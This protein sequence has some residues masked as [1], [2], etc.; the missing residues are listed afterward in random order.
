MHILALEPYY[1]G[2]HRAFLDGWITHSRHRWSVL[3]LPPHKWKWR[4]RH[5]A[6]TL[7]EETAALLEDG[8]RFDLLW[9]SDML[10]LAEFLGL[11]PPQLRELPSVLYFHENQLTYP[12][13]HEDQRDLHF[14]FSNFTAA[15]AANA[16]WF[17]SAFH[18]QEF[19]TAT[20]EYLSRM[21]DYA[22]LNALDEVEAKATV[23]HPGIDPFP[24][25]GKRPAGPLHILWAA[26]WE[27][28]KN[29][30]AF[31][32]AV[33]QL[34]ERGVDFCLSVIGQAFREVPDVFESAWARHAKRLKNWGYQQSAEAYRAALSSA[35]VFVSTA[36]HEFFGLSAAEAMSAGCYP[37]L[38][39]RLAYPELLELS[40]RPEMD[41][42]FYDGTTAELANS[43]STIAQ[44]TADGTLWSNAPDIQGLVDRFAWSQRADAMDAALES[45]V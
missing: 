39:R 18:R 7:A 14:A 42:F 29:P 1:G 32:A 9:A 17:N 8:Q 43:L 10:N 33:D 44:R 12:V 20:R 28:D 13:R 11:A 45:L 36:A 35:D 21:P 24:A 27:H 2:S 40:Q 34:E 23:Q 37:M 16:V 15:L 6:V 4:M 3:S 30:D 19:L 31:F 41:V 38:P 26:R 22:P 5:A 25:R